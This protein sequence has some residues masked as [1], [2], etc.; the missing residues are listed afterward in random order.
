MLA[1]VQTPT[2]AVAVRTT[3]VQSNAAAI[4]QSTIAVLAMDTAWGHVGFAANA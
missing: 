2:L 3:K 1:V 4:G